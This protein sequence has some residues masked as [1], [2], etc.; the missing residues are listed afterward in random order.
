VEINFRK[1]KE[2]VV[3]IKYGKPCATVY[4]NNHVKITALLYTAKFVKRPLEEE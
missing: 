2:G 1:W 3:K 4:F